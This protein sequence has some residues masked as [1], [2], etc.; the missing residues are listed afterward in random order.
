M[1]VYLQWA[2]EDEDDIAIINKAKECITNG[3]NA[4]EHGELVFFMN[5]LNDDYYLHCMTKDEFEEA[6][7]PIEC[8]E[9]EFDTDDDW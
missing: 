4:F 3:E 2:I 9:S 6:M 8:D 5:R 1:N 7:S